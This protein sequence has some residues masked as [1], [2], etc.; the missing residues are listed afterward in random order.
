MR[1]FVVQPFIVEGESMEPNFHDKEY[2]IIDK[3]SYRFHQPKRGEVL[4]FHPPVAV[5]QNYIKRVIG[6]PGETIV[7]DQN[8]VTINGKKIDEPYLGSIANQ[9]D[10]FG[11]HINTTLG[12]D[13]YFVLGDNRNHSSDSREWGKLP[14]ANIEGRTWFVAIPTKNFHFVQTPTY[15]IDTSYVIQ[16]LRQRI[17]FI[18]RAMI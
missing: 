6:L 8:A 1:A 9:P 16:E 18:D 17:T 12:K 13:E 14:A 15:N 2:I 7:I 3:L 11:T 5:G 4:V 10:Q